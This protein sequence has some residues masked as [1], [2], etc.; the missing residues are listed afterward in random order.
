MFPRAPRLSPPPPPPPPPPT[1]A[2]PPASLTPRPLSPGYE[3]DG[4]L[5]GHFLDL[6]APRK[7]PKTTDE[8][9]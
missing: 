2:P 1:T 4:G 3:D 7:E 8:N 5:L 6:P 9:E